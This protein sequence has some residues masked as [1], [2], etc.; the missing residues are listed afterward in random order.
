MKLAYEHYKKADKTM[1][2]V[3]YLAS[4][5]SL[6]LAGWYDTWGQAIFIGIGT[7]IVATLLV[8][9]FSGRS[10]TRIF[11]GMALMMLTALH[12][13]QA[14]GM[15]EMHFG[16]FAFL[17][18]LLYYHDWKPIVASA[19]L[20]AV[21][22]VGLFYFQTQ[23]SPVFLLDDVSKGWGI[24]FLHAGYVV[25]ETIV[26]I[27]MSSNM[28]KKEVSALDLQDTVADI[29][30]NGNLNLTLRC[31]ATSEIS[32]T[33]NQ[34]VEQIQSV[35]NNIGN[36]GETLDKDSYVM[37]D[38]MQ[39]NAEQLKQQLSESQSIV[40]AVKDLS[41]AMQV[42]ADNAGQALQSSSDAQASVDDCMQKSNSTKR[43]MSML[44]GQIN[45]SVTAISELAK[46]SV[47]IGSVLDVIREIADQTN[48]LAL[49]AA[50]EAARAGEQG[51][52]FAVVADEVRSLA[53][54]TQ[55]STQEIQTM[56]E[57]LQSTSKETVSNMSN[58]QAT[59][60]QCL[61][62]SDATNLELQ[63]VAQAMG[64]ILQMNQSIAQATSDQESVL[65]GV[66]QNANAMQGLSQANSERLEGVKDASESVRNV[67]VKMKDNIKIFQI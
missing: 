57:N 32:S 45:Q 11:M 37:T 49:N 22:H 27:I 16:F 5:Y 2:F 48:L 4:A 15:I 10:M 19:A 52:G 31:T 36:Y 44:E 1:L 7:A 56:I 26:L 59:M 66:T 18:L 43:N 50:I 58:S 61:G 55:N 54:R 46:D 14:H 24:V 17:A 51:R 34:F 40:N 25:V 67:A 65:A 20:V 21:H 23:G 39:K 6:A 60:T 29:S 63:K 12:V 64:V 8:K 28:H 35:I 53:S 30:Q 62:D 38:L 47:N 41:Q 42:I 9:Y 13:N 33:F 3:V